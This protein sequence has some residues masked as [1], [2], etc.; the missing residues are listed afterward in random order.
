[1]TGKKGIYV[2][3]SFTTHID[4]LKKNESD[5]ILKML[6]DHI[7]TPEF[8]C[9]FHWKDNSVAFWDNRCT[10]HRAL[11]DYFP[12]VRSGFRVTVAGDKPF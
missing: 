4:G 7:D 1:M 8:H 5:A 11:W 2:N 6:Y 12:Q 3:S 9:R 10:Q